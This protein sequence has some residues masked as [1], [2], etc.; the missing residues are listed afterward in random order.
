MARHHDRP[1]NSTPG[2]LRPRPPARGL[3]PRLIS[4]QSGGF[5]TGVNLNRGPTMENRSGLSAL[6]EWL[7]QR[8]RSLRALQTPVRTA[9]DKSPNWRNHELEGRPARFVE[10][11]R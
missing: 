1:A 2:H 7:V 8:N 3:R 5:A 11:T 10:D 9:L 6:I 4:H